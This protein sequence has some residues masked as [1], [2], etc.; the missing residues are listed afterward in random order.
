MIELKN[1]DELFKYEFTFFLN[2]M[3]NLLFNNLFIMK[4]FV[5]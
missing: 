1:C 3:V 4:I 5:F 2:F